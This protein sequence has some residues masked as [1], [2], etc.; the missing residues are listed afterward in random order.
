M[1]ITDLAALIVVTI[2]CVA[3]I[4]LGARE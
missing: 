1:S 3:V 4:W 2:A